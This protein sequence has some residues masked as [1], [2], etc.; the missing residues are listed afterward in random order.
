M[1]KE[2]QTALLS[3]PFH[4]P[5]PVGY[6]LCR[7][8]YP[9]LWAAITLHSAL[10]SHLFSTVLSSLCT[11]HCSRLFSKLHLFRVYFK[12]PKDNL[13]VHR[14]VKPV[15]INGQWPLAICP[16]RIQIWHNRLRT[17]Y[18]LVGSPFP[19][20]PG[21]IPKRLIGSGEPHALKY[22]WPMTIAPKTQR[23]TS[24]ESYTSQLCNWLCL[25]HL[26]HQPHERGNS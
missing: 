18:G 6:P 14:F 11:L 25:P 17:L 12:W 20:W 24:H 13:D 10:Y 2:R 7:V 22:I 3:Q 5:Q 23:P 1:K 21:W 9:E 16:G 4:L 26:P 19:I 8:G 15:P